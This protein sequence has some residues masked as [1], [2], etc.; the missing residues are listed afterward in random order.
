MDTVNANPIV[1]ST[2][3]NNA[4]A[5][6]TTATNTTV[7]TTVIDTAL[8][9]ATNIA[10]NSMLVR[11]PLCLVLLFLFLSCFFEGEAIKYSY[12][13]MGLLLYRGFGLIQSPDF[14]KVSVF[15]FTYFL[16][17]FTL[18]SKST[19]EGNPII[20]GWKITDKK[21]LL[22]NLLVIAGMWYFYGVKIY[23][24]A[25]LTGAVYAIL[26]IWNRIEKRM[27]KISKDN[28]EADNKE[29]KK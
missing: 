2:T 19:I 13:F 20:K 23:F 22:A 1:N 9:T 29:A 26:E 5:T 17:V 21:A 10:K 3:V 14:M 4:T 28:F 18:Y 27:K 25:P 12:P 8:N 16:F 7:I 6:N 15:F 24:L 11:D